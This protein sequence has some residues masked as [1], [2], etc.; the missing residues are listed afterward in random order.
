LAL[1]HPYSPECLVKLCKGLLRGI[2]SRASDEIRRAGVSCRPPL[3]ANSAANRNDAPG[4]VTLL[5]KT[6]AFTGALPSLF[7]R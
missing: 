5:P 2:D 3:S 4:A 1:S 7:Y 6:E